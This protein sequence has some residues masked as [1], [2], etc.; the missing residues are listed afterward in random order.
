MKTLASI[1][2]VTFNRRAS[3]RSSKGRRGLWAL[4]YLCAWLVLLLGIS[5]HAHAPVQ[6]PS[7]L[8]DA[9]GP[10]ASEPSLSG[11]SY[12]DG[13]LDPLRATMRGILRS[14][15][16]QGHSV[17]AQIVH[18]ET[19]QSLY[20]E[21]S[22]QLLKPASTTKLFSSAAAFGIL[23]SD[24]R[25][26]S[27]LI[28]RAEPEGSV[29]K[30]DLVLHGIH[31]LSWSTLFY[32]IPHYVAN[33]LVDDLYERGI[34]EIHGDLLVH[35]LFVVDGHRFGTLDTAL[36][37]RQA[38]AMLQ[39][40]LRIKG[41]QVRGEVRI[42]DM[43]LPGGYGVELARWEGPSLP[44]IVAH[45]NRMSHNEFADMMMLALAQADGSSA[46][47]RNGFAAIERWLDQ[48]EI[49]HN[50]LR[51][52][53]GSGLSHENRVSAAHLTA[54]IARVQKEPWA[55]DWNASLSVAGI[56]GTYINRM[57]DPS[58]RGCAWLKSGT[59]N[60]VITTAGL[61]HHRGTGQ[62]Y[63]VVFL[64]NDIRHQPSARASQDAMM[65]G[66]GSFDA[67][68]QR[69]K[70]PELQSALL[71]DDDQVRL[72]WS[73]QSDVQQ[74]AVQ[75]REDQKGWRTEQV[76][77][78]P[79]TELVLPR[80]ASPRAYRLIAANDVGWSDP[81]GVLVAGGPKRAGN[82]LLVD[83]NER[84]MHDPAPENGLAAPHGFL[85]QF[86]GPLTGYR[87]ESVTNRALLDITPNARTTV[88]FALGEEARST[89]AMS[90]RERTW[91]EAHIKRGGSVVVSG[92]EFAWDLATNVPDGPAFLDRV[93][94]V[95]LVD[96]NAGSTV[97][98]ATVDPEGRAQRVCAHFWTPGWMKIEYPDALRATRGS[99]CMKYGGL[100]TDACVV[101][102]KAAMLGFPLESI[103]NRE[104][105]SAIVRHVLQL[106]G[107]P[108]RNDKS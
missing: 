13:M 96:D 19:G 49:E 46:T 89:E 53:D 9:E 12:D 42:S 87:V 33:R 95:E 82:I 25:P 58:T 6:L 57:H 69:P 72:R 79:A 41:I 93:F 32:P 104:D 1:S 66:I 51:L 94:G 70:P 86:L 39:E 56:D 106:V 2:P 88:L 34:R 74:I 73:R 29:L 45:I 101:H 22:Q 90:N 40:R 18:I 36:E 7:D 4:C 76:L 85:A 44:S 54:L 17:S 47:Y 63:A 64:M 23:G 31:D 91:V 11:R 107:T 61:L 92:S 10:S 20:A 43:P 108:H 3:N 99:S 24:W 102:K 75:I 83:G 97:A 30:G 55:D 48:V 80:G 62:R 65:V 78:A 50:G 59:L 5:A 100:E 21:N 77:Q 67:S 35:G 81:S 60:G 105:R 37:R 16:L 14:P 26:A 84:W 38:G 98:C 27:R 15:T 68:T 52:W 71:T 103:D 28:A 8:F